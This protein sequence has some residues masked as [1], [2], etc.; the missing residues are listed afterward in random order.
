MPLA[1]EKD[2]ALDKRRAKVE[3]V[4]K[5]LKQFRRMAPRAE[6]LSQTFVACLHLVAA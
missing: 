3:R 4:C 6:P 2:Q 5:T 1:H